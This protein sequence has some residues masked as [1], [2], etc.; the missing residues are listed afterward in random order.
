MK[1]NILLKRETLEDK[2]MLPHRLLYAIEEINYKLGLEDKTA[3]KITIE[4]K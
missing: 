4:T 1:K 3:L 2:V